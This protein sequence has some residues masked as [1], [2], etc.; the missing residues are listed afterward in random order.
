[1]AVS[2]VAGSSS[3][4][5]GAMPSSFA[6]SL[7]L[8]QYLFNLAMALDT[9]FGGVMK[10]GEVES[11]DWCRFIAGGLGEWLPPWSVR[12]ILLKRSSQSAL[13]TPCSSRPHPNKLTLR[14]PKQ[15]HTH[16][17]ESPKKASMILWSINNVTVTLAGP[18]ANIHW[19][20]GVRGSQNK[21]TEIR[22]PRISKCC[23]LGLQKITLWH[24]GV[25][26]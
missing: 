8:W 19:H 15:Q 24:L 14:G 4:G 21:D 23:H 2:P 11:R 20:F 25:P 26:E 13:P 10:A 7:S 17:C 3:S 12:R 18:R 22:R 5:H 16:S 6:G 9:H 1:M